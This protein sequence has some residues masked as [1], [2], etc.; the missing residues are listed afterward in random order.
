[1]SSSRVTVQ[2]P[3]VG[4]L[5]ISRLRP[6]LVALSATVNYN[7]IMATTRRTPFVSVNLTPSA[8]DELRHATLDLTTP[9]GR[10]LSMSDVLIEA[11]RVAM[12]H[13][14]ELISALVSARQA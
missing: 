2:A 6:T 7:R 14:E 1:M 5:P 11:I 8:R 4:C 3:G 13:Q 12:R 10:R 9:T